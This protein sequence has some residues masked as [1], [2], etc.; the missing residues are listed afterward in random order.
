MLRVT[1]LG[2]FLH[3]IFSLSLFRLPCKG[4]GTG[5]D[6]GTA[7]YE[8]RGTNKGFYCTDSPVFIVQSSKTARAA[9]VQNFFCAD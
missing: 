5:T 9:L 4:T 2:D 1:N 3:R 8:A 6:L 7:Q